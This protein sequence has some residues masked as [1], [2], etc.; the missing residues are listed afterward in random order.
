M[1]L[2][3]E[4]SPHTRRFPVENAENDLLSTAV[5]AATSSRVNC[6][7]KSRRLISKAEGFRRR[8]VWR[9]RESQKPILTPCDVKAV[10]LMFQLGTDLEKVTDLKECILG[11]RYNF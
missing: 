2:G 6:Q 3:P 10:R 7:Q 8:F 4:V 5:T 11:D 9:Y 1:E